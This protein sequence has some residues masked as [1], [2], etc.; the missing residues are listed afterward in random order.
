[1]L[2]YIFITCKMYMYYMF[3]MF[4]KPLYDIIALYQSAQLWVCNVQRTTKGDRKV[5]WE[6]RQL[7]SWQSITDFPV[8]WHW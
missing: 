1:M 6:H 7:L 3:H 2:T 4:L 8:K 5:A